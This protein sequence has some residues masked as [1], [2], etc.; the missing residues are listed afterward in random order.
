MLMKFSNDVE[1][2]EIGVTKMG[3]NNLFMCNMTLMQ[4]LLIPHCKK[5]VLLSFQWLFP[6]CTAVPYPYHQVTAAIMVASTAKLALIA[7]MAYDK[8]HGHCPL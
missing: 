8:L 6:L 1:R 4:E 5:S 3:Q 2:Y 7:V